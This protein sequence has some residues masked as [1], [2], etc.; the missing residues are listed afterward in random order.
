MNKKKKEKLAIVTGG[1]GMLC[2]YSAGVLC[3]LGEKLKINPDIVVGSSGNTGNLAYFISKQF[4]SIKN[5]WFDLFTSKKFVNLKRI[6]KILNVD[7]MVDSIFKKEEPLNILK[8]KKSKIKFFISMTNYKTGRGEYMN[9]SCDILNGIRASCSVPV[10]YGKKVKI[11]GKKYIDGSI[12]CGI[13]ENIKKAIKED[14]T[15]IIVIDDN[16]KISMFSI[17]LFGFYS[18]F[19]N[20]NLRK[21]IKN[22][23]K[24]YK[25][26]FEIKNKNVKI[27]YI[28]HCEK[29]PIWA[30]DNKK[31]NLKKTFQIGYNEVLNNKEL[32]KFL[33]L[34]RK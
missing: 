19:V 15:K 22:Y 12:S 25:N 24:N 23:C 2:V 27:L 16:Q 20:K 9:G 1:G 26:E 17:L 13:N 33:D 18:Y 31:E 21:T 4:K 11:N 30:L 10:V 8:I 29:L 3:A 5:I 34:E 7:Y 28:K 32:K 14:A 6:N